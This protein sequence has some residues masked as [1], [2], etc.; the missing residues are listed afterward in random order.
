MWASVVGVASVVVVLMSALYIGS[1]VDP[2]AHLHGLPVALVD[3]D[4]GA[5]VGSQRVDFGQQVQ[6]ALAGSEVSRLLSL[7]RVSS[8]AS[9][10]R[11]NTGSVYAALVIPPDFTASLLALSGPRTKTAASAGRPT[12]E[13]LTNVR[14]GT[15]G[16]SLATGVLQPAIADISRAIG[17]RLSSSAGVAGTEDDAAG[18]LLGEPVAL[19]TVTYR[20]LPAH[21]A[22]GLSA[23]Y[24]ALLTMLCGFLGA[25]IV[26]STTDAAL[27]YATLDTGPRFR[28]RQPVLISRWQTLLAKWALALVLTA[29]LCGLMLATA[30]GVMG[31][32]APHLGYL[33]LFTW[34]AAASIAAGTLVLLAILGNPGQLLAMLLFVYL[35]LASAGGTVPLQ[36]LPGLLRFVGNVEPL[37]QILVGV[38][39]ILYFGAQGDAGLTRGVVAAAG[40]LVLWLALGALV[41]RWYDRKGLHRI[42][43]ATLAYVEQA[44]HPDPQP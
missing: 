1:V 17:R 35:G 5:D 42:P 9:L 12:I 6:S 13:L 23:F 22:L 31:M 25:I 36:A 19:S 32:D 30:V 27:G 3:E 40:G 16:V 21:S 11:L 10:A 34:L 14:A 37:R 26:N 4:A 20:P 2:A 39:A 38:R 7:Q 33:W 43:P 15:E 8:P 24:T 29:V 28:Q 41:V 44:V 18:V